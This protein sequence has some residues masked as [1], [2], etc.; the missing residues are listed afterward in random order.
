MSPTPT[1]LPLRTE[2]FVFSQ[3]QRIKT[4]FFLVFW[5]NNHLDVS[6]F[7]VIVSKKSAPLSTDRNRMKRRVREVLKKK[8]TAYPGKDF[9][10]NVFPS[11]QPLSFA[12]LQQEIDKVFRYVH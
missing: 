6:R 1:A 3:A 12:E 7:A 9:F 10:F 2:R 5:K 11:I 4:P 8:L